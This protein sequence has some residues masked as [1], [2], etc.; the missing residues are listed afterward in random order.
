MN[1]PLSFKYSYIDKI[2]E[3]PTVAQLRG[4]LVHRGLQL[5]F[6]T[7]SPKE[8]TI[9]EARLA[10]RN[11]YEELDALGEFDPLELDAAGKSGLQRDGD[12]LLD[13]YFAL[14]DP[15]A[16]HPMGLE[17]DLRVPVGDLELRGIID[18]LDRLPNGDIVI[19]DYKTGRAPRPEQSRS[20]LTGVNFYAFMCEQLLGKR[21]SEVRLMYLK[22]RVVVV[23]SPTE[24]SMRGLRNRVLAIWAAITRACET[25]DFRPNPSALCKY[26]AYQ[27]RC[28]AFSTTLTVAQAS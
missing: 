17:L 23:E 7:R 21:P 26:C 8:R 10:M 6:S 3:P 18:R 11:A 2:P 5:L 1:C 14:E 15:T 22:D 9:D 25:D 28:P 27:D 4:T 19:V 13:R 24:Q 16:V 12:Q 20:R